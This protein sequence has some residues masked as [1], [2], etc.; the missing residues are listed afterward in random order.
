MHVGI[1]LGDERSILVVSAAPQADRISDEPNRK[2]KGY[3]KTP[4]KMEGHRHK[5][6]SMRKCNLDPRA[7]RF[8]YH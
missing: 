7:Y 3:F 5:E 2:D 1:H 6:L 8:A 4:L